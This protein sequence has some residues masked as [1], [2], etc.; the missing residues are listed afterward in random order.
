MQDGAG[1][2]R[3]TLVKNWLSQIEAGGIS[4]WKV[5]MV[6]CPPD[7]PDINPIETVWVQVKSLLERLYSCLSNSKYT[8]WALRIEICDAVEYC[9]ELLDSEYFEN[10]AKSM[11]ERIKV[12]ID[13]EG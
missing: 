8:R 6:K 13:A 11:P 1:I 12:V 3:G 5:K 9:W 7:S 10:L 4:G 2:H